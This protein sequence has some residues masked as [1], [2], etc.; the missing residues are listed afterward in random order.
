VKGEI[1]RFLESRVADGWTPG[2]AWWVEARGVVVS[3]G[4]IGSAT[5]LPR[6][7]PL[8]EQ[9]PFD[10]ASL[11]KPLATALLFA[12]AEQDGLLKLEQR[13]CDFLPE[14]EGS[15]WESTRLLELGTHTSGLPAWK[16]LCVEADSIDGY[17][18]A[19]ARTPQAV[20]P[21]RVLYSDLGYI[22]LGA[23][24][25]R[26]SGET[27]D[28]LFARDVALPLGLR[29]AGFATRATKFV[30][31]AATEEG[32]VFE[33]DLAGPA[34][35]IGAWR[36]EL[37]RGRVHDSN[38][39]GLGGV[40]GHAGLFGTS[41]E[42][43]AIGRELLRPERLS[44]GEPAR[45]RLLRV[46]PTSRGRTFGLQTAEECFATSGILPDDAPGHTGFTGTS[47]WLDPVQDRLFVLL[48]NRVHPRVS[49][50]NFQ[51]VR[52]GFHRLAARAGK[53]VSRG[54]PPSRGP[55]E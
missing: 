50:R 19:I 2:A 17:V 24:L 15:P 38:A 30:D 23:V 32:S 44:L 48:T 40:A 20:D 25:E 4:A 47:L 55:V 52:R 7:E 1:E 3:R 22:L 26:A 33:R 28:M 45:G 51:R 18:Q 46:M 37:I 34:G 10:L 54:A 42:V 11:T 27:L 12:M 35:R 39:N 16:P 36:T 31:A 6:P 21:G 14:L 5:L 43:A 41:E 8:T 29:R 13:A 9:T 49:S 53:S